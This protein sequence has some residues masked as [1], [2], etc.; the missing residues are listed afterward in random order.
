MLSSLTGCGAGGEGVPAV[1]T[2]AGPTGATASLAWDPVQD[3]SVYAYYVHYGRQSAGQPGACNYEDSMYVST[4]SA[5]VM[6][7]DPD[8]RYFFSVSAYNGVQSACSNEV[9]TVTPPSQT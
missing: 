1:S 6:G 5:T 8:T 7:L 9:S 3:P 4:P 2:S